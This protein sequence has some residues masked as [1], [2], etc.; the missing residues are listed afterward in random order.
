[1]ID[2][3]LAAGVGSVEKLG[4]M[5]PEELLEIEGITEE[6]L[7]QIG[8]SV[9]AYYQRLEAAQPPASPAGAP[10]PPQPAQAAEEPSP[11]EQ[12]ESPLPAGETLP[13]SGEVSQEASQADGAQVPSPAGETPSDES[14]TMKSTGLAEQQPAGQ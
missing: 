9:N 6:F 8:V 12:L 11:A 1:V 10:A 14:D 7:A 4:S 5:T 2:Q 13:Q 3:L